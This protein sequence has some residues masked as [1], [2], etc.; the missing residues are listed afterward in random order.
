MISH[1][2]TEMQQ[3]TKG[4]NLLTLDTTIGANDAIAPVTPP[5]T[6]NK[7]KLFG[8]LVQTTWPPVKGL[9]DILQSLSGVEP[10]IQWPVS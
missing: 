3:I 10:T 6:K 2:P 4:L 8:T 1:T 5:I 7:A 9:N